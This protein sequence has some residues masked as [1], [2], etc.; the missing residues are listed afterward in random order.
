MAKKTSTPHKKEISKDSTESEKT[1]SKHCPKRTRA[2]RLHDLEIIAELTLQGVKQ[3][4]IA[5][6][7]NLSQQAVSRDLSEIKRHWVNTANISFDAHIA[8]ELAKLE[9]LEREYWSGWKRSQQPRKNSLVAVR[10]KTDTASS[11]KE[12]REETRDGNPRFLEGVLF[13]M[14]RKARLLGLDKPFRANVTE[15]FV[16]PDSLNDEQIERILA[17]ESLESVVAASSFQQQSGVAQRRDSGEAQTPKAKKRNA[18][19]PAHRRKRG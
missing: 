5:T 9:L 2:Q 7:L 15:L 19:R 13:V 16:Q 6:Q 18:A 4:V 10:E 14:E 12:A 1:V 8:Q 11:E 17:G 3:T